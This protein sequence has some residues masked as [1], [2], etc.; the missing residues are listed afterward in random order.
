MIDKE[1]L[2]LCLCNNHSCLVVSGIGYSS[3]FKRNYGMVGNYEFVHGSSLGC[4]F[5]FCFNKINS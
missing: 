4:I 2:I 1:I 3:V 5:A